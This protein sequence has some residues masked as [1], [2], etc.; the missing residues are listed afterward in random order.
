[1]WPQLKLKHGL[2]ANIVTPFVFARSAIFSSQVYRR[3]AERPL[4]TEPKELLATGNLKIYQT[5]GYQL[6]Q[7]DADVLYE[8]IRRIFE[9]DD[10]DKRESRVLFNRRQLLEALGRTPGG[11][12][13]ALLDASIERLFA[14][15]FRFQGPSLITGMSRLLLSV[16]RREDALSHKY[17]YEV[18]IDVRLAQLFNQGSWVLL[19]RSE[20]EK[21]A[22]D[23]VAKWLHAYYSTHREPYPIKQETLKG[24]MGREGMQNSKWLA[25]LTAS[26]EVLKRATGWHIC[27]LVAAGKN[28]GKV[29]VV[30][31]EPKQKK[32]AK[33]TPS[34]T[35]T[36]RDASSPEA[37]LPPV[38]RHQLSEEDYYGI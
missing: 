16:L 19:R 10:A 18:L 30:R 22:G 1:M 28:A 13:S 26:L 4:Y 11:K 32:Q 14:A 15:S 21:L 3:H 23:P 12:T 35:I 24:L 8:L 33:I 9:K 27:E 17:D 6:D 36:A 34:V 29:V 38:D 7:G 2:G 37:Y 5:A 20:R 25:A 31:E